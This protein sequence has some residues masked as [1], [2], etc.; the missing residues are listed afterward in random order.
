MG[1]GTRFE[2]EAGDNSEMAYCH[3]VGPDETSMNCLRAKCQIGSCWFFSDFGLFRVV[4]LLHKLW[5]FTPEALLHFV[6]FAA[7]EYSSYHAAKSF[8][9]LLAAMQMVPES[10][11]SILLIKVKLTKPFVKLK[12]PL[13]GK[14]R[15][16]LEY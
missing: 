5:L 16:E 3:G 9:E 11:S 10:M 4:L 14:N 6:Q 12:W 8:S 15:L 13:K 7:L 2:K 1:A